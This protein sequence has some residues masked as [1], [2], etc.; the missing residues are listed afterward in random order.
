MT[1]VVGYADALTN[2]VWIGAD[3]IAGGEDGWHVQTRR[4]PKVFS[5]ATRGGELLFGFTTSWRMGQILETAVESFVEAT[6]AA[7]KRGGFAQVKDAREEGGD[8]LL[9]VRGL[10]FRVASDFQVTESAFAYDAIGGGAREALG[11]FYAL[12]ASD[13]MEAVN[14]PPEVRIGI[15]LQAAQEFNGGVRGPFTILSA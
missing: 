8:F 15:A 9:G 13:P 12:A 7:M 5:V 3:S 2:K 10:L 4:T 11:A 1:C 14:L 6:R